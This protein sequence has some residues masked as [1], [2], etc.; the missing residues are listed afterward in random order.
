MKIAVYTISLNEEQFVKRWA[1]SAKDADYLLIADTGSTDGTVETAEKLGVNVVKIGIRPWR[2]DDARNASLS[3][4]PQDVDICIALDMDE[5]LV[6]GWREHL[7]SIK[8]ETTRPR[9]QYTWSWRDDGSPGLVYGGDKIHRRDGYRWR[10]PVHETITPVGAETQEWINLEIHHFPDSTK[11]RSQYFPLLELARKEA[12]T[13]DRTAFYYARELYYHRR[14]DEAVDEFKRFLDLPT[15]TWTPE[16]AAAMRFIAK[17]GHDPLRWYTMA[18][19][20]SP[21][22]REPWVDLAQHCHDIKDWDGC[23]LATRRALA[24]TE[25]AME[26][27]CEA[28]AWG[29]RPHDLAS[30]ALWNL[31]RK[32]EAIGQCGL[33]LEA[34]PDNQRIQGNLEMMSG[35]SQQLL[36]GSQ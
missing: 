36:D 11:S 3:L 21:D 1:E 22:R 17:S 13:D 12:P 25:K 7:E 26:Y 31:G 19:L 8:P 29:S 14:F 23:L 33:A 20:E 32:S 4:I 16:R 35:V 30:V 24:I 6:P 2:F 9:Y 28:E 5:L 15:A 18:T 10:H 34:E 27:L